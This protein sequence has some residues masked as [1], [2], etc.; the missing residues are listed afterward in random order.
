MDNREYLP[1]TYCHYCGERFSKKL[2]PLTNPELQ[3]DSCRQFSFKNPIPVAVLLIPTPTRQ[4]LYVIQ[5]GIE[6]A[7]GKFAIPGGFI[8]EGESWRLAAEREAREEAQITINDP[9]HNIALLDVLGAPPYKR[10]LIFGIVV[11]QSAIRINTFVESHEAL[12]RTFIENDSQLPIAF[13][14]HALMIRKYLNGE[15]TRY[16]DHPNR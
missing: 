16:L 10:T 12:D 6:P 11:R 3:C 5:R 4:G 15:F 8:M 14:L 9:E 2:N 1:Y 13:P 7:Q